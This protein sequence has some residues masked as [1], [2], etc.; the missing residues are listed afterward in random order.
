M[1]PLKI[2]YLCDIDPVHVNPYSGGNHRIHGALAARADVTV[3]PQ[4]WSWAEPLRRA[5]YKL[6]DAAQLRIRWRTRLLAGRALAGRTNQMLRDGGFDVV[7]GAYSVQSM[8]GVRPPPGAL[9]VFTSDAT[10]TTYR[11]SDVGAVYGSSRLTRLLIDPLTFRAESRVYSAADLLLWP[12]HWLKNAADATY[13][14][15]PGKA[16]VLAWGANVPD[17]GKSAPPPPP[18]KGTP[19]NLLIIARDWHA[20]GGPIAFDTMK[21]LRARG[22]DARLTVIGCK[23]PAY[24][25]NEFVTLTG[26]LDK[27]KP[28]DAARFDATLRAAHVLIQPSVESYGFAFCEAAAHGLPSVCFDLG[29]VPVRDGVTGRKLPKGSSPEDFAD[30]LMPWLDAPTRYH[31]LCHAARLDYETRLNWDA[32]ADAAM[33]LIREKLANR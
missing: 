17:P 3:L 22:I 27:G 16:H 33:E 8:A 28:A 10:P 25:M 13:G 14:L 29:G 9:K 32:W 30:A 6:P 15:P 20:K 7:F 12:S 24:H 2:A 4:S 19:L 26:A 1:K 18:G 31:A 23:P 11:N 5:I 21:A